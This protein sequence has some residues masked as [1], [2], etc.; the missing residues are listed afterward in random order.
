[1]I[2]ISVNTRHAY[3]VYTE[4]ITS[5]SSGIEASFIF[6][7]EWDGL[8]KIAVFSGSGTEK[9]MILT[10]NTVTVPYEVMTAA[11]GDLL[12]GV[13]GTD[14]QDG[15]VIIPTVWANVGRIRQGTVPCCETDPQPTAT[16]IDQVLAAAANAVEQADASAK[17]QAEAAAGY[18]GNAK[19]SAE[20]AEHYYELAEQ[21]AVGKGFVWFEIGDDGH[22]YMWRTENL[23]DGVDAEIT[24]DGRLEIILS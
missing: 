3:K 24:E 5:G 13:Y 4:M 18:A 20:T 8:T 22:L 14:G 17:E 7:P 19:V 12:V 16:V 23:Q 9:S 15:A 11:G 6:S 2:R 10:E 21:V 1:M